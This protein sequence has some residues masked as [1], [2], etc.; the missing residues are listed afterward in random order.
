[1][2]YLAEVVDE[3]KLSEQQTLSFI[4][5]NKQVIIKIIYTAFDRQ[6]YGVAVHQYLAENDMA[7]KLY[8][9]TAPTPEQFKD[10]G[11]LEH[12]IHMEYLPPPSGTK[13]GWISLHDLGFEYPTV[14]EANKVQ[15]LES[16]STIARKLQEKNFV[17]GDFRPNNLL[18]YV[19]ISPSC[20]L[21]LNDD[22]K[23]YVKAIDFDWSGVGGKVYYPISLNQEVKWPGDDGMCM[24]AGDDDR[25]VDY[26]SPTW[27]KNVETKMTFRL[28]DAITL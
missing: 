6:K 19:K 1:V 14:A 27:P 8:G 7:P 16:V 18:I 10:L 12:Y 9:V 28:A 25:M 17:H 20:T 11:G 21:E 23:P 4:G 15:I 22:D 24:R 26:W 13:P 2:V 5:S 3:Q